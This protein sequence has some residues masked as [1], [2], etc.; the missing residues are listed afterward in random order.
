MNTMGAIILFDGV[1]NLCNGSVQFIIK[2]D[3]NQYFC[4]SPLQ[5]HYSHQLTKNVQ[6]LNQI[7][8]IILVENHRYY[9]KSTAALKIASKLR[10]A[11]KLLYFFIIVPTPL[12]DKMYSIIA[13]HRYRWFGKRSSCMIPTP[14]I[15]KRFI[16]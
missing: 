7:D 9:T 11:W 14:D 8:S 10:G 6:E 5:S 15:Q 3:P 4:F 13:K 2:R 1:C 16:N 12:R